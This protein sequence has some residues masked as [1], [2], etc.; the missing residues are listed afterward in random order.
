M[1][2]RKSGVLKATRWFKN[3]DHPGDDCGTFQGEG[4]EP[5]QGEGHVVRY[6]RNPDD[7]ADRQCG[8]CGHTMHEHGWIDAGPRGRVVCP[9]DYVAS[10]KNIGY[11]PVKP[12]VFEATHELP[13]A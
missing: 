1:Y 9:G 11:Y 4:G 13:E 7:V 3:G 6:Y 10:N 2:Y 12:V 8:D 5:F